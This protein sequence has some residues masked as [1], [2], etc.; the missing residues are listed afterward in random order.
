[1]H[2]GIVALFY[3]HE[4]EKDHIRLCRL[5]VFCDPYLNEQTPTVPDT[6]LGYPYSES[7]YPSVDSIEG[8]KIHTFR[9]SQNDPEWRKSDF[10]GT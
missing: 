4:F 10:S 9:S 8:C 1:M 3:L 5:G 2:Y 7:I 6:L